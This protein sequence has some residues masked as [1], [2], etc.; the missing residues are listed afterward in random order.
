M[1][2][3][4]LLQAT[5]IQKVDSSSRKVDTLLKKVDTS[6]RKVDSLRRKVDTCLQVMKPLEKLVDSLKHIDFPVLMTA[7][8]FA[9]I[10][11]FTHSHPEQGYKTAEEHAKGL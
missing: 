3:R 7:N 9:M 10:F 8:N 6:S 5:F 4:D 2:I 1:S 11:S